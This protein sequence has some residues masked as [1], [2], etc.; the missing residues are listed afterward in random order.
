MLAEKFEI[1]KARIERRGGWIFCIL[2]FV[3]GAVVTPFVAKKIVAIV[4]FGREG[5]VKG[6]FHLFL[7][8]NHICLYFF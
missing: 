3:I 5:V 4:G 8:F 6:S 1:V 7:L 2:G